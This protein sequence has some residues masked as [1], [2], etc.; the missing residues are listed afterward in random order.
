MGGPQHSGAFA[1]DKDGAEDR[2]I[3][4]LE[5]ANDCVDDSRLPPL[6]APYVPQLAAVSLRPGCRLRISKRDA[7]HYFHVLRRGRRWKQWMAMPPIRNKFGGSRQWVFHRAWPMG[8]KASA[9]IAQGVTEAAAQA[10]HLPFDRQLRPSRACP[11]HPPL[12]GI[13][14]DDA[15]A[16]IENEGEE[17]LARE[18]MPALEDAWGEMKVKSHPKKRVDL[19]EEVEVLGYLTHGDGV[20]DLAPAKLLPLVCSCLLCALWWRPPR[21]SIERTVGKVGHAHMLRPCLRS[22]F[23]EVYA[24]I[25]AG[26][27]EGVAQL[28]NNID[29][30]LEFIFTAILLPA[31]TM[32]LA[33]PWSRR[34]VS[35]DA[36]PGGHG[37]AY[38]FATEEVVQSWATLACHRGEYTS[39]LAEHGLEAPQAGV[40]NMCHAYL[41]LKEYWWT[42]IPKPGGW[43]HIALEEYD[44]FNWSL[45]RR[46]MRPDEVGCRVI[47][48]GDNT[49]QVGAHSKGRS[50]SRALNSRCRSD[51]SLQLA[52]DL[53]VFE[54]WLPSGENPSDRPSRVYASKRKGAPGPNAVKHEFHSHAH[55]CTVMPR[56]L[57]LHTYMFLHIFSGPRRSGDLECWIRQL[58]FEEGIQCIAISFDPSFNRFMTFSTT[59]NSL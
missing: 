15:F 12:W 2:W 55:G 14:M 16:L 24:M 38:T 59:S 23:A 7:R 47:Q 42:E 50:S 45:E 6:V 39:L 4:P 37:E 26:R 31:V 13:I 5:F 53:T 1:V 19:E 57:I 41:P 54:L 56:E 29:T 22:V 46:L 9:A 43:A 36:A 30:V 27:E 48:L 58:C 52:G 11:T 49:T 51:A 40:S 25:V 21:Q 35:T 10:A 8:F 44:A 20:I 32:N 33:K 34:V 18:W 3:S 17:L 28:D